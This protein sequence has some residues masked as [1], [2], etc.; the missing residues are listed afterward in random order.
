MEREATKGRLLDT[1]E[2][3]G[4][5]R[6]AQTRR[7]GGEFGLVPVQLESLHYLAKA[8]R[9]S[10]TPGALAEYLGIT[11]GTMSQS[12]RALELKGYLIKKPDPFDKRVIHCELTKAGRKVVQATA[13]PE[14]VLDA[15]ASLP[16]E[17]IDQ[18]NAALEALL[19]AMETNQGYRTFGACRTC[20]Y[21]LVE[22]NSFRCELTGEELLDAETMLICRE[23]QPRDEAS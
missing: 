10:D 8:N 11:K 14:F 4:N 9:Y 3:L 23:N 6:R 1:L 18:S 2:R 19:R 15:L 12:I 16:A 17:E 5:L 21:F 13:T 7:L 20:R 22:P